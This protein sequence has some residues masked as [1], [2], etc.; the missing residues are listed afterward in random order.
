MNKMRKNYI[1][2]YNKYICIYDFCIYARVHI[3]CI[4]KFDINHIA[5]WFIHTS[6]MQN[7]VNF[8]SWNTSLLLLLASFG[9]FYLLLTWYWELPEP[10]DKYILSALFL[11][12]KIFCISTCTKN[13]CWSIST[14]TN[15]ANC[16]FLDTYFNHTILIGISFSM[17]LL[18]DV[19]F[20][21]LSRFWKFIIH[22]F[23]NLLIYYCKID[24]LI[25]FFSQAHVLAWILLSSLKFGAKNC[26]LMVY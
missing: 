5:I 8:W 12:V 3:I 6:S 20:V 18:I 21:I 24:N 23:I 14:E 16:N 13:I 15:I 22:E 10:P 11:I 17:F 9:L 19:W 4:N 26:I 2:T 1:L 25:L 7:I